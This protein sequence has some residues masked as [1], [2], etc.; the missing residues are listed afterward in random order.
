MS[1]TDKDPAVPP[2]NVAVADLPEGTPLIVIGSVHPDEL[3]PGESRT[4][5]LARLRRAVVVRE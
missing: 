3:L 2:L 5:A 4:A 1:D